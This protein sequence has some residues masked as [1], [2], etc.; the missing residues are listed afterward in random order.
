[1]MEARI[2]FPRL[3]RLLPGLLAFALLGPAAAAEPANNEYE[4]QVVEDVAY[5]Q[6][7]D[8]HKIKHKLDLY[9]PKGKKDF[10]VLVFIHGGAWRLGDKSH[11]GLYSSIGKS[12]ARQ[13]VG[14]VV[15]NYRL[16]P[17]VVH[18]AHIQDVAK[19]FAWT[20]KNIKKYG[21]NPKQ[22]FVSGHSAG[23]HLAALLATDDT[24]LKAEGLSLKAI[25]G[26]IPWSGLFE[27]S[28]HD[29]FTPM[30]G[31]DLKVRKKAS[32]LHHAR[33]DAPPF[34]IIYARQELPLCDR[35]AAEAFCK[36][37]KKKK[38]PAETLEVKGRNHITLL[39][40]ASSKNDPV[41]KAVMTFIA[42]HTAPEK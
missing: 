33:A 23:G 16:S 24:Y 5:Y 25:K 37:L 3:G 40:S 36:A 29:M 39:L 8:A 1:M 9:L 7:K 22:I 30:F 20:Y 15:P 21:G 38:C 13:G 27:F 34:L 2:H 18:P 31:K 11:F 42:K 26:A 32:P 12:F 4:V 10:P 19:A 14:T 41:N 28:H 6:G 35:A 17:K